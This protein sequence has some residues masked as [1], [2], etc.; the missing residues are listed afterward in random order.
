MP[1][2]RGIG[3]KFLRPARGLLFLLP[4]RDPK[5]EEWRLRIAYIVK[6]RR[7]SEIGLVEGGTLE[8][9]PR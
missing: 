5:A 4:A 1:V 8:N 9:R 2:F 6:I 7:L 3:L